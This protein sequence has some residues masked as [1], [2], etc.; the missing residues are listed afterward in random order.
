MLISLMPKKE[1]R[2]NKITKIDYLFMN[3][4]KFFKKRKGR[5]LK[6]VVYCPFRN[7]FALRVKLLK[8]IL[9]GHTK[10]H[11]PQPSQ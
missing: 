4:S 10:L 3:F 11:C 5:K 7:A 1:E 2:S 6:K 9:D 8:S